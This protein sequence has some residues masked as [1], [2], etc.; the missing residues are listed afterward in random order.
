VKTL[1]FRLGAIAM[2][3]TLAAATFLGAMAFQDDGAD[4][5]ERL[6]DHSPIAYSGGHGLF[7]VAE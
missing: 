7:P 2:A 1:K 6:E 3:G 4:S 5:N